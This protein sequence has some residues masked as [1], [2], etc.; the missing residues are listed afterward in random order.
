[1]YLGERGGDIGYVFEDLHRYRRVECM[2]GHR[3]LRCFGLVKR[4]I[5]VPIDPF[6]RH[7]QHC[8]GDVDA[9]DRAIGADL[10]EQLL[11][12]EAGAATHVEHVLPRLYRDG[13]PDKM[14][15]AHHIAP[16]VEHFQLTGH[17]L[18]ELEPRHA[19]SVS[20]STKVSCEQRLTA[21]ERSVVV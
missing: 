18:V 2:V 6:R 4:N 15:P 14:P 7:C 1:M 3:Q 21:G 13:L 11:D 20:T 9:S 16:V 8:A 19:S 5:V 17:T 10:V 12:I